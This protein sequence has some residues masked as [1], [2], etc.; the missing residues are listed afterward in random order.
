[1]TALNTT[2]G[3]RFAGTYSAIITEGGAV[4]QSTA[5][6]FWGPTG[7]VTKTTMAT[8]A[9]GRGVLRGDKGTVITI[10]VQIRPSYNPRVNP[11]GF[12]DGTDN[13]GLTYQVQFG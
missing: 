5:S 3:E 13:N 6:N 4:E 7:T 12:G 10:S 9:A 1:M 8:M 2:T 11:S